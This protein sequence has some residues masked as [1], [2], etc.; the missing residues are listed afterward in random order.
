M[1]IQ[2]ELTGSDVIACVTVV[3][4]AFSDGEGE[5]HKEGKEEKVCNGWD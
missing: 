2:D 1:R 3:Q 4:Q 5:M